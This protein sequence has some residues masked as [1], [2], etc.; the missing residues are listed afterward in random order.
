MSWTPPPSNRWWR[1][2][3]SIWSKSSRFDWQSHQ[4]RPVVRWRRRAFLYRHSTPQA[5]V[6]REDPPLSIRP[7]RFMVLS[8]MRPEAACTSRST[9]RPGSPPS[10]CRQASWSI[11]RVTANPWEV[12]VSPD[13]RQLYVVL[14]GTV[15]VYNALD[16]TV[17][18]Y[19]AR[20]LEP[21]ARMEVSSNPLSEAVHRGKV[22]FYS[23]LQ[24][25]VGRR[26]IACASCHP[27]GQPDGQPDGRTWHKPEGL[28]N[29][30]LG[31]P[32]VDA[33]PSLVGR[34]R[35]SAGFRADNSRPIDAG[36]R[37]DPG[38]CPGPVGTGEWGAIERPGRPGRLHE[39]APVYLESARQ[40]GTQ[41]SGASR[42]RALLLKS[43][44]M[45][46]CPSC[47]NGFQELADFGRSV[48]AEIGCPASASFRPQDEQ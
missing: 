35:R 44:A 16:F 19:E 4:E 32:R 12:T 26:W 29:T 41:P 2:R 10:T 21:V 11:N 24:P 20:G 27:D 40:A 23:A 38:G 6:Y 17:T 28:R 36:P 8:A 1:T 22:L 37:P 39:L 48:G 31:R 5:F 46:D 45:F 7:S 43:Y 25:M 34:P 42:P 14:E 9:I 18:A 33:P 13:G 47:G 15:Y 30:V 3:R